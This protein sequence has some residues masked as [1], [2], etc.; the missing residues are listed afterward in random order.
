M[1]EYWYTT[2]HA[3]TWQRRGPRRHLASASVAHLTYKRRLV[4]VVLVATYFTCKLPK[5]VLKSIGTLKAYESSQFQAGCSHTQPQQGAAP[6][7][8]AGDWELADLE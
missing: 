8:E 7:E 4:S 6:D 2:R 5:E 3:N 1:L